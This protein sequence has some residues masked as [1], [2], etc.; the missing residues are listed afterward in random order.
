MSFLAYYQSL[1]ESEEL[2][3]DPHQRVV[4]DTL[5]SLYQSFRAQKKNRLRFYS[6]HMQ[7]I[8]GLYLWGDVGIGKTFLMRAFYHYLSFDKKYPALYT[9]FL[10]FMQQLHLKLHALQGTKDP[11]KHIAKIWA[12]KIRLFCFDEFAVYDVA[13][14]LM[15]GRVLD[16]FLDHGI[17]MICTA[18]VAPD[19]LYPNGMQR[20]AFL[21]TIAKI[22][23]QTHVIK[24]DITQD[25]RKHDAH[26]HDYYFHP[27]T[28][29]TRKK[30]QHLFLQLTKNESVNQQPIQL[31]GREI[32]VKQAS[33]TV[34]CFDFRTLCGVPRSQ[35]DYISLA[36]RFRVILISDLVAIGAGE[37]NLARAFIQLIDI[38]YAA[39][40]KLA[41]LADVPI[42]QIYL[43]QKLQFEFKRTLSRVMQM[44]SA[45]WMGGI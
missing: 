12:K 45:K 38:L 42:G 3:D 36:E 18:N 6:R 24:L 5:Q 33:N 14:A 2:Q 15:L 27:I 17:S 31:Y 22:K 34:V 19:D 37:H 28:G 26:V 25:Y 41:I 21:P 44:Q 16:T 29:Q 20:A 11:L 7:P 23:R 9:H 13:D 10:P 4:V 43:G 32:S 1:L 39:K 35:H 30:L 8:L 40:T